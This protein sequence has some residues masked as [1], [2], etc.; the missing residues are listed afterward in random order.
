VLSG[1]LAPGAGDDFYHRC[2]QLARNSQVTSILDARAEPLLQALSA[3][4]NIVK[5]NRA[6]LASTLGI[7]IDS[8][9]SL[10]DAMRRV[11]RLGAD[12]IIVTD[13]GDD[14]RISEG[15][16]FWRVTT[17]RIEVVNP[18]GSG[19]AFAAGLAAGL[20]QGLDV[21]NACKQATAC[22]CANAMTADAG[23]LRRDDV[24]RFVGE[25]IVAA[26]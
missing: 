22:A 13:S 12:W 16:D 1:T 3:R 2:V 10:K 4:P 26:A 8:D 15:E 20:R 11:V 19:D 9:E 18:I 25:V 21:P 7:T 6:E 24:E 17:P 23:H 14:T 5:L